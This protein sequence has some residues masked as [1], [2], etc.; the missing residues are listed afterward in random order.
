MTARVSGFVILYIITMAL[1]PVEAAGDGTLEVIIR[2][3]RRLALSVVFTET[4]PTPFRYTCI[5]I[6][7]AI[8]GVID[9]PGPCPLHSRMC[10]LG[11]C[12]Q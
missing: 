3:P 6:I 9:T 7:R 12:G 4:T 1:K 10:R 5:D 11:S 2:T 8:L